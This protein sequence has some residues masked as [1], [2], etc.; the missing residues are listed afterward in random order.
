MR[1]RIV[2]MTLASSALMGTAVLGVA[3]PAHAVTTTPTPTTTTTPTDKPPTTPAKPTKPGV[4]VHDVAVGKVTLRKG[5]RGIAVTDTQTRLVNVGIKTTVNGDYTS[6]TVKSVKHFQEKF[7]LRQ[8]GK[9]NKTTYVKLRSL[10]RNGSA[11]PAICKRSKRAVCV[12]LTQKVL[13]YY[14]KGDLVKS[15]DV[16]AGRPGGRTRTGNWRIFSKQVYLISTEYNTPMPYS[17][18]FSGG[19]AV[20]YS[21]FFRADGYNGASHGCLGIRSMSD[22][23]WLFKNTPMGTLM[24]VYKS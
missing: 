8:T 9:V 24:K 2:A 14:A 3:A 18:F 16:R 7:F 5:A 15:I 19:Q 20:H 10:T 22:A 13:R 1:A 12:D 11:V 4:T 17:M 23:R 6:N 21:M